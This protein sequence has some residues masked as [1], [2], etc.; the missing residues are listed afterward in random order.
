MNSMYVKQGASSARVRLPR[1]LA[2]LGRI[3]TF[4]KARPTERFVCFPIIALPVC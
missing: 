2:R 1:W 3:V 4:E